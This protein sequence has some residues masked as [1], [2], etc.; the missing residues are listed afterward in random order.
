MQANHSMEQCPYCLSDVPKGAKKCKYCL[1]WLIKEPIIEDKKKAK[2]IESKIAGKDIPIGLSFQRRLVLKVPLHYSV[3]YLLMAMFSFLFIQIIW[4]VLGENKIYL[5]S[6]FLFAIQMT[7]SAAGVCWFERLFRVFYSEIPSLTGMGKIESKE[8]FLKIAKKIFASKPAIYTGIIIS[9]IT[10]IGDYF[11][12]FPFKSIYAVY[13]YLLYEF[14]YFFWSGLAIYSLIKFAFFVHNFGKQKINVQ[15]IQNGN[16]GLMYLGKVHLKTSLLVLVPFIL[17]IIARNIGLWDFGIVITVWFT[18]FGLSILLYIL[19]PLYNIHMKMHYEKTYR[20]NQLAQEINSIFKIDEKS[21]S[22]DKLMSLK[23]L[24][25]LENH[26]KNVNSWP[27]D[28]NNVLGLFT[29]VIVPILIMVI[30]KI[31][32]G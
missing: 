12:G 28:L 9:T 4:F 29:A 18:F 3:A 25:E 24:L 19:W 11:L 2:Y 6:F 20:L 23:E 15:L 8:Y 27:F 14:F 22:S 21:L 17:G 10:V 16:S 26:L 30:D 7:V 1:E 32:K 31:L 13:T 5:I